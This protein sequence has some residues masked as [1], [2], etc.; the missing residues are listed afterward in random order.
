MTAKTHEPAHIVTSTQV[1]I[2]P[3]PTADIEPIVSR[4]NLPDPGYTSTARL[5]NSVAAAIR[6]LNANISSSA[7]NS[8]IRPK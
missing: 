6:L 4:K 8:A 7:G 2:M 3:V 5:N 1:M